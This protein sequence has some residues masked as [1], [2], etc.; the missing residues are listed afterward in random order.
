MKRIIYCCFCLTAFAA[1][2]QNSKQ[3][4][5]LTTEERNSVIDTLIV[6][7]NALYVYQDVANK[8]TEAVRKH[9]QR[10]DYDTITS[11]EAFA[12]R[13]TADLHA[14]NND[15]HLGVEYSPTPIGNESPEAPSEEVSNA[16]RKKWARN[17]FNFKKVEILDGNIGLLQLDTFFPADW[18]R[19]LAQSSM[20]F[21]ANSDAIIIDIRKNHGFADG[22]NLVASYFFK[23]AVHYNDQYD[24]DAKTLRQI[25]TMAVVPGPRLADKDIYILISKDCFSAA[26]DFAYN[27]QALGRAKVIG[28]VTGG[29]A[30]PTKPYKIGAHFLAAIPFAYSI[31]PVTQADWEGKG[32]VPDVKVPADKALLTA[33]IMA[34]N[35]LIRRIP[36]ENDRIKELQRVIAEKEKQLAAL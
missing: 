27:M 10:H 29:G 24:R 7:L 4:S 14:V 12:K 36:A 33:Q 9:Q 34:I 30:H 25:W 15:G 11:R 21:L 3:L 2:A 22:G 5:A 6:K 23:E 8:M 13:L 26:E 28:E 18:I 19:D 32:V 31:N 20:T 17:N 16:F 35:A 1:N